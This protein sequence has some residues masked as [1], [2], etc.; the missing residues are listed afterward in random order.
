MPLPLL[1]LQNI[2]VTFGVTALLS[3]AE[4]AVAA[5]DRVCLV[6]SNGSGK[7]TL[8]RIA[9]GLVQPDA[10]CVRRSWYELASASLVRPKPSK[11]DG[12][13]SYGRHGNVGSG[14]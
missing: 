11:Q 13:E 6:G 9:T 7:S 12:S 4:L 5:G 2:S 8:L 10:G 1:L 14:A 3:G